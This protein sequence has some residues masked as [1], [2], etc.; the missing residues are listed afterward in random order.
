MSYFIVLEATLYTTRLKSVGFVLM[1][2]VYGTQTYINNYTY[3]NLPVSTLRTP[4]LR[5][6]CISQECLEMNNFSRKQ[7]WTERKQMPF[8]SFCQVSQLQC[9]KARGAYFCMTFVTPRRNTQ[10]L[11]LKT[12]QKMWKC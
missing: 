3:G 9:V 11:L 12:G 5:M 6:L 4:V 10:E 7:E 2:V 1:S 8:N